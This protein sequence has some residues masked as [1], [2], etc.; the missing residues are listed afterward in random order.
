MAEKKVFRMST[1]MNKFKDFVRQRDVNSEQI[2]EKRRIKIQLI[3]KW[4]GIVFIPQPGTRDLV[5]SGDLSFQVALLKAN[6]LANELADSA[7]THGENN[8]DSF[9]DLNTEDSVIHQAVGILRHCISLRKKLKNEYFSAAETSV[10]MLH[11]WVDPLLYKTILWLTDEKYNA[12]AAATDAGNPDF[13][14]LCIARDIIKR[15]HLRVCVCFFENSPIPLS[16][17]TEDELMLSWT[18]SDFM[19]NLKGSLQKIL[20]AFKTPL[21]HLSSMAI[22][23]SSH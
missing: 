22:Q 21:T 7:D 9:H 4:P 18:K 5:C 8:M 1:I 6:K 12:A 11:D 20:P 16:L 10:S 15:F 23:L 2:Y 13:R 17:F 14:C 19:Q 3:D